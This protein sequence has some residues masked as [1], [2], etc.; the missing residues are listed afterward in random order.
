[1]TDTEFAKAHLRDHLSS[2]I[3]PP[4]AEGFWSIESSARDLCER[5]RT[6][7]QTIRTFQNMLTKIPDWSEPTLHTEVERIQKVSKCNYL[8]DLVTGVSIAYMKSFA[9]LHYAGSS[10]QIEI[11][12]DRPTLS[13]FIHEMY[14]QSARKLWQV[15]YLFKTTGVS[16]E[17]Q[18]RARQEVENIINQ[19]LEQV[20]RGFLPWELI[21]KK[22]FS[23]G[24]PQQKVEP[25][26]EPQV[27]EE[28]RKAVSFGENEEQEFEDDEESDDDEDA[29]PKLNVS[30]EDASLD[31]EVKEEEE[32]KDPLVEIEKKAEETLVLNL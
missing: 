4:I 32:E 11:E 19:C 27:E 28:E 12:F 2:L 13:K 24:A 26:P 30:E 31:L 10:P 17:V 29:P 15:A 7:D 21:A 5:N 20:I 22:Y 1:M 18:A 3:V 6:L 9:S 23:T 25:E 14:S 8:D 16:T